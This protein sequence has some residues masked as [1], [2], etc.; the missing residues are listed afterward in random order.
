MLRQAAACVKDLEVSS[1]LGHPAL[2]GV[3]MGRLSDING[4][5]ASGQERGELA[6]KGLIVG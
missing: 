1:V 5:N 6:L 2:G 4:A 3:H